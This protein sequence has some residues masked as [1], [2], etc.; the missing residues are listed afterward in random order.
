M[1]PTTTL[2]VH[3]A[4]CTL[5]CRH[6]TTTIFIFFMEDVNKR[7]PI[8]LFFEFLGIQLPENS[9]TFDKVSE[10]SDREED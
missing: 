7:R 3:R 4:F 5:F 10:L 9:P 6:Y 8:L 2:H 1:G